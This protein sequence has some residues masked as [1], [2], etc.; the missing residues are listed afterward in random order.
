M[1]KKKSEWESV[2]GRYKTVNENQRI[3]DIGRQ[4]KRKK[5]L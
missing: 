2:G 1:V 4:R 3:G 5:P